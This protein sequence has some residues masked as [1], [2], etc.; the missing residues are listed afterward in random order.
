MTNGYVAHITDHGTRIVSDPVEQE[1]FITE[2]LGQTDWSGV[3]EVRGQVACKGVIRGTARVLFHPHESARMQKGDI[4]VT[5]MTH[6]D[7]MPAIRKAAAIVT[8]EGGVV[9]HAAVIS[10]ELK[11]PCVIGTQ[12]GTKIF[13]DGETI[14][15]DAMT[16]MVKKI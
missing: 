9:C 13:R 14:E 5:T 3:R 12:N 11:I 2:H 6:P 7:Y 1:I 8:D 16:G 15:V 4:L 10:R